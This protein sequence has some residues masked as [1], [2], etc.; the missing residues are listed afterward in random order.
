MRFDAVAGG[1][2]GWSGHDHLAC[3]VAAYGDCEPNDDALLVVALR[4]EQR[5]VFVWSEEVVWALR[6]R[7]RVNCPHRIAPCGPIG[8][9]EK[10]R[11]LQICEEDTE[12]A[13]QSLR[14]VDG[15]GNWP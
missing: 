8:P 14:T 6:A 7:R 3:C 5:A 15:W 2:V 4:V 10:F 11:L 13:D 1:N 12:R 9:D